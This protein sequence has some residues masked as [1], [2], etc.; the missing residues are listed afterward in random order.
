ME[1]NEL[2]MVKGIDPREAIVFRH[3][4]TEPELNKVFPLLAAERPD[5]Y[6]AYQQT[7]GEKVENALR[8]AKYVVSFIRHGSGKALFVGAYALGKSKSLTHAQYWRVPA[9]VELKKF[10]MRGFIAGR[11]S[12]CLWFDLKPMNFYSEWKGKLIVDWPPP[13]RSWWR[14]AHRNKMPIHAILEDSALDAAM[15]K[16]NELDFSWSQLSVLPKRWQAKLAEWRG[17]YYIFDSSD[18]KGYVGSAYGAD[19][20]L[21]RWQHYGTSG[22]GGN[23]LLRRR[24]PANFR[25]T[26]LELVSPTMPAEEVQWLESN[27]KERLHTRQPYGLNDN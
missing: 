23:K 9:H 24:D 7:H 12:S 22:H 2:L 25:F 14:R 19:N 17:I 16:W 26:I 5:L 11:R 21:G 1:L 15:Q 4:P 20:L 18:A 27:W 10:G 8:S 3:R 13:E 6:N